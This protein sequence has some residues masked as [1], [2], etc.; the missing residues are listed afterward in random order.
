MGKLE[1]AREDAQ[2]QCDE[3]KVCNEKL[4]RRN[5]KLKRGIQTPVGKSVHAVRQK[6]KAIL[7]K[8]HPDK[9]RDKKQLLDRTQVTADLTEL[10]ATLNECD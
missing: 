4:E 7:R 3:M 10:L 1:K 2:R 8:C 9:A 6:L 5:A